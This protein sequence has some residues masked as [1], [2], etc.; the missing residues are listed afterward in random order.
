MTAG[1]HPVLDR[2]RADVFAVGD[3]LGLDAADLEAGWH[4]R[5]LA[6]A[7]HDT[8]PDMAL[9]WFWR[10]VRAWHNGRPHDVLRDRLW[11]AVRA[12]MARQWRGVRSH[13]EI[14]SD[15]QVIL[16]ELVGRGVD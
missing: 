7:A 5:L 4:V 16:R 8:A 15:A 14:S 12:R 3:W 2:V 9:R 1:Y 11:M 13:A 6:D 10:A